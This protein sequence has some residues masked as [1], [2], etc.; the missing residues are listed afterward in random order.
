MTWTDRVGMWRRKFFELS[1][2]VFLFVIF[3]LGFCLEWVWTPGVRV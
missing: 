3:L 1:E 2:W